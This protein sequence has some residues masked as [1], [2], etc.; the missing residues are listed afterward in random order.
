MRAPQPL[1]SWL[2]SE[3]AQLTEYKKKRLSTLF[4][5]FVRY[6]FGSVGVLPVVLINDQ[7]KV[8]LPVGVVT[9]TSPPYRVRRCSSLEAGGPVMGPGKGLLQSSRRRA[10]KCVV[11]GWGSSRRA[12][13]T[14][15]R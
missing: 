12:E 10:L 15:I 5:G 1:G 11:K 8:M 7:L 6:V 3:R 13:A 4:T 9:H 2:H 14:G